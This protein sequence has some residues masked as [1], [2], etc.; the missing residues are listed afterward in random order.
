MNKKTK[1]KVEKWMQ[2]HT[3][4]HEDFSNI[5][6]LLSLK[7][8]Q[9][10]RISVAI[11]TLNEG[12]TLGKVLRT[13]KTKLM[14]EFPLIDDLLVVDS[15]S[16]DNTKRVAKKEG[17]KFYLGA[18]YGHLTDTDKKGKGLNLYVSLF[19]TA[20]QKSKDNDIISWV[21]ADIRNFDSR[22]VYG[23]V[24]VLLK[25]PE[26]RYVKGFYKR[27]LQL[28]GN[29]GK[30]DF[31]ILGGGRVTELTFRSLICRYFPELAGFIQPLSG[32]YAGTRQ[33]LE[34]IAFPAG[35]SVETV[36]LIEILEKYGLDK[37]AQVDLEIRYHRNQDLDSL[38]RMAFA[39]QNSIHR[40]ANKRGRRPCLDHKLYVPRVV[41]GKSQ[42]EE[43]ELIDLEMPPIIQNSRYRKKRSL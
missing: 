2:T 42:L 21:D 4:H 25:N 24:G 18:S 27:P 22:F 11:P 41:M 28:P 36:H 7:T 37:M 32:E 38:A 3:F 20:D 6:E 29:K 33:V 43:R 40:E 15:G 30:K 26:L 13:I 5:A 8:K 19:L 34:E 39:I 12:R 16:E 35:Y 23:P 1:T 17:S 14:D 10:R 9:E 31:S